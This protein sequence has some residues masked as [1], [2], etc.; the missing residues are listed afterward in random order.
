[1]K[2]FSLPETTIKQA[3]INTQ[4][5][6]DFYVKE[7]LNVKDSVIYLV[8]LT[9]SLIDIYNVKKTFLLSNVYLLK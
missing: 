8:D 9:K 1:M 2:N 3:I 4:I 5:C 6:D 7:T